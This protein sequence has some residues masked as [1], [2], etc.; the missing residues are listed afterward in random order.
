MFFNWNI[1]RK[2]TKPRIWTINWIW[3]Q[4]IFAIPVGAWLKNAF[5]CILD[6]GHW[7]CIISCTDNLVWR[8]FSRKLWDKKQL[9]WPN[10][11]ETWRRYRWDILIC[12]YSVQEI[13]TPAIL[14]TEHD[15]NPFLWNQIIMDKAEKLNGRK[16][17]LQICAAVRIPIEK[18]FLD[19]DSYWNS[20]LVPWPSIY[21]YFIM[22]DVDCFA[23]FLSFFL[24]SG[25]FPFWD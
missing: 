21:S 12:R 19:P 16:V 2:K 25:S 24:L 20:F 17:R 8:I 11:V 7:S 4:L 5:L 3:I 9:K 22:L 23:S 13:Y 14:D 18:I 15:L 1:F 10:R 6:T